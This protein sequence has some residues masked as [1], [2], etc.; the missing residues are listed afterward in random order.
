MELVSG[1]ADVDLR[2]AADGPGGVEQDEIVDRD[3]DSEVTLFGELVALGCL[4]LEV[5]L[6]A[7]ALAR[8][9]AQLVP[10]AIA[11]SARRR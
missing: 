9:Q 5:G 2:A 3:L 6:E 11:N 1:E 10:A 7:V 8:E 4:H